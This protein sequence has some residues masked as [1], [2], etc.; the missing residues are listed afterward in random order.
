[1]TTGVHFANSQKALGS[2]LVP[3]KYDDRGFSCGTLKRPALAR[4]LGD[5]ESSRIDT[6]TA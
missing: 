3:N 4:L 2:L 1:M 5:I 6:V